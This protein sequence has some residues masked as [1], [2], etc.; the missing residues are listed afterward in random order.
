MFVWH[1]FATPSCRC[2]EVSSVLHPAM[3]LF[4]GSSPCT[5][6]YHLTNLAAIRRSWRLS[7]DLHLLANFCHLNGPTTTTTTTAHTTKQYPS[8]HCKRIS[9]YLGVYLCACVWMFVCAD[10][11]W[12]L[13]IMC[14]S[15]A[16]DMAS[17]G[18]SSPLCTVSHPSIHPR[19]A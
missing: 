12:T 3:I 10:D 8:A 5:P 6:H 14:F 16:V 13:N 1:E 11:T 7:N 9:V 4:Q 18:L 19:I 15:Y 17:S 2:S